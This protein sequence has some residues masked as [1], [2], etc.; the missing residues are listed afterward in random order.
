[1]PRPL[2]VYKASA[3]SGK[4][5]TLAV[6][7]I[8]LLVMTRDADE[9]SHI[10][11]VTFTNKATTE[12]KDRIL[13]QL[14]GI[15]HGLKSSEPYLS[16]L[17]QALKNE[18]EAPQT[19]DL[20]RQ[21]CA[22][23]LHQ[24]LHDY[25]RFRVQTIDAFFQTILRGL[26][27]E[28]GLTANL[29]VEISDTEV[30]SEAVDRIVD[31]L[32]DE[33]VVLDWLL[34]LVQDQ[35]ENDQRWDVTNRVK[36][37]GKTIF[38]EDYLRRG[39]KLRAVLS[40]RAFIRDFMKD[41]Q[42]KV[43]EGTSYLRQM[44]GKLEQAMTAA[45]VSL[46][47][48]SN[49]PRIL[50]SLLNK[51]QAGNISEVQLSATILSWADDPLL[52]VKKADQTRRPDLL[53]AADVISGIL[54]ELTM[55]LPQKQY[56]VNSARQAQAHLKPLFL[57]DFI[58]KEVAEINAETSRFNLAKTPILLNRMIGDSDAPFIFEKMGALL[59][60]VMIDEFQDTSRL[61]WENFRA[62]LLESYSRGGRNLLVGDV[63]QSIYRWRGGDW[64]TLG[65][66]ER[67]VSP[68]PVIKNLDTNFR[69]QRNVIQF[70]NDFFTAAAEKLDHISEAEEALLEEPDFFVG[71]YA[72][73][74][75]QCPAGKPEEGF[76]R[77]QVLST[78]EY[79]KREDWEPVVLDDLKSQVR[80]LHQA[81]LPYEQM[82]I[83]VRKNEQTE[84]II[85]AFAADADMPSVVSDE[86]F[87][88][89]SCLPICLLIHALRMLDAPEDLISPVFLLQNGIDAEW[90]QQERE[91]LNLLPLS[92]L[93]EH[94]YR[95]F[96][97]ERFKGQDAYLFAFFDAVADYLHTEASD[98][99][100]F[101]Q[102]W[103]E[104]LA[105]QSIPAGQVE[106]IRVISIHKSKG[107]EFHTVF[108]PFC[109][110]ELERDRRSDLL[111]CMPT[112]A[113]FSTLQL[114]PITPTSKVTPNSAFARDYAEEHLLSRLDELNALY[115]AFTRA[116]T[117]LY[118]W[119]VGAEDKDKLRTVGDLI[120]CC[121]GNHT[122]GTPVTW[123]EEHAE[124]TENNRLALQ[125]LPL[126]VAMTSSDLNVQ[127]RQS[128]R[129][130]QFLAEHTDAE[131][132]T[133]EQ[134][135]QQNYI[136]TGRLLHRVLQNIRTK[137]DVPS[138]LDRFER[139]GLISSHTSTGET[140]AVSRTNMERWLEQG[141]RNPLVQSWFTGEW[142]LFNE[143]SIVS[144]DVKG[145]PAVHRPDRVMVSPDQRHV[146][147]VDFKFGQPQPSHDAQVLGYMRLLQQ[148][149]PS[150]TIKGYL[151][152]VY[153]GRVQN[154]EI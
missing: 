91:Q 121:V 15:A 36:Q 153:T 22:L 42:A 8:K 139:E 114:I 28:L 149:M 62:L 124:Q 44:A 129:S 53:E 109:T 2:T 34:S 77:V 122:V 151:W 126:P 119:A 89:A 136:E 19:D 52:M 83:L 74:V 131:P 31:R 86:A 117:N 27:H 130:T 111:W 88:L 49:G 85:N 59:H 21:R 14:Y 103:D 90:L 145:Q 82:T 118:I 55:E 98:I 150:A 93:L 33:P 94:L 48:F 72:D 64:R 132:P 32:Q 95:T 106:G 13:S 80:S 102:Y 50:G 99:H 84:A 137:E 87:L 69:S 146:T 47:D 46:A 26:A 70:N 1:M 41:L 123:A 108:L 65:H 35:I 116:R 104:H 63:K 5:F 18:P 112:E 144:L 75:Q 92:E 61:Q 142:E 125:P 40:D 7:Y 24:I 105:K 58:D 20:I 4:T 60:H 133:P 57:L 148:M 12:M 23:S 10:L 138:T 67:E 37:F 115:V 78:E 147:V 66:I 96:H 51:L 100:S 81:G 140:V 97:L 101:L 128:N 134:Q 3:G 17:R 38:N 39:D 68:T 45:G 25:S 29:Q 9:F 11:G 143:C 43:Q 54:S 71:A 110:W 154:I 107:L 6:Q 76:V 30:L 16:A 141:L 73:V 152:Y 79:K 120:A 113:P 56:E 127:F 135:K